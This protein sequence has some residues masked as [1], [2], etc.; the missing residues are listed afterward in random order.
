DADP[1]PVLE[2]A[3]HPEALD[4]LTVV[5]PGPRLVSADRTYII[6]DA[7]P[8]RRVRELALV[9]P[10]NDLAGVIG[11]RPLPIDQGDELDPLHPRI[12][13]GEDDVTKGP[14]P[15]LVSVVD[16]RLGF[17]ESPVAV[18]V[19]RPTDER[20]DRMRRRVSPAVVRQRPPGKD[21]AI[22]VLPPE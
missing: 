15:V 21:V 9:D 14:I 20:V 3:A 19:R 12:E 22:D 1:A 17:E 2:N 18:D 10:R 13:D 16:E 8:H 7:C 5:F 11:E 6:W 4:A